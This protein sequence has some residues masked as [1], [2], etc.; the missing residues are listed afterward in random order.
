MPA[1]RIALRVIRQVTEQGAYASLSLD[2]ALESCGL[3]AADRRLASRLGNVIRLVGGTI[4]CFNYLYDN[5]C[6]AILT[7]S[8]AILYYNCH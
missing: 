6:D 8:T 5:K 3:I 4:E 1:R 7:D 2:K